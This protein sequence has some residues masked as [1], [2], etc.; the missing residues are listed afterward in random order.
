MVRSSGTQK[1]LYFAGHSVYGSFHFF[2][3]LLT[4]REHAFVIGRHHLYKLIENFRPLF[5]HTF[6]Y[7]GTGELFMQGNKV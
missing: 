3:V 4:L 6:R 2:I 1:A 5:D 7:I